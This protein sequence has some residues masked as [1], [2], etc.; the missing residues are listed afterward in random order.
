ML[1]MNGLNVTN[2]F[3]SFGTR[4]EITWLPWNV[5][6]VICGGVGLFAVK[7]Q[8]FCCSYFKI[9]VEWSSCGYRANWGRTWNRSVLHILNW[10]A[11][12]TPISCFLPCLLTG[13]LE[14][15][16]KWAEDKWCELIL[17]C[18]YTSW[19]CFFFFFWKA[20]IILYI[21][22]IQTFIETYTV[23]SFFFYTVI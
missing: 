4:Q 6:K 19:F 7:H 15:F 17:M 14:Y 8:Y 5:D 10:S 2:I 9:E 11:E 21:G 3:I 18:T 22:K 23:L 16:C 13:N 12:L 20:L 1:V